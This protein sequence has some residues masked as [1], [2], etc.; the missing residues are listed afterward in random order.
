MNFFPTSRVSRAEELARFLEEE[1]V[2]GGVEP[3][4]H[5]GT[6]DQLRQRFGVAHATTNE[7]V[8][9]LEHRGLITARSG[10]GG[11]V[12]VAAPSS[13][14]R[15]NHLVLGFKADDRPFSDCLQVRNALEPLVCREAFEHCRARDASTLRAIVERMEEH[16]DEPAEF[17]RLNWSLHRQL[18]GMGSNAALTSIYLTLMDFVEDG[19]REV[20]PDDAFDG[21]DNLAIHRELVEAIIDDQPRRLQKAIDRHT[22]VAD[23]WVGAAD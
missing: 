18:A 16:V 6:K 19:L 20:E 8:R 13:R 21:R 17:L 7:A 23:R 1:I 2:S 12:F 3:G 10:P 14:V 11:G 5:L 9:L 4:A 15:L 22:P